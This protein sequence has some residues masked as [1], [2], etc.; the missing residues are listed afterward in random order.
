MTSS[1]LPPP[2]TQAQRWLKYGGNVVLSSIVV[3]LLAVGIVY[4]A[5]TKVR[6]IDTTISGVNSLRP[7]T[8]A[9]IGNLKGKVR[10]VSLYPLPST[11]GMSG[12]VLDDTKEQIRQTE[13]VTDLLNEYARASKNITA[14][15]LDPRR[16]SDKVDA[17]A[18]EVTAKY[19]K[20]LEPYKAFFAQFPEFAKNFDAFATTQSDAFGKLAGVKVK[21]Q[22]LAQLIQALGP[23]I[24]KLASDMKDADAAIKPLLDRSIPDYRGA[25]DRITSALSDADELLGALI[26][27]YKA[28]DERVPPELRAFAKEVTPAYEAE[29][30]AVKE[31][32][33]KTKGLKDLK[34]DAL[35]ESIKSK[36]ILVMGEEDMRVLPFSDVWQVPEDLSTL[37]TKGNQQPRLK[38]AGEQQIST[39]LVSIGRKSK[40]RVI[41]VRTGGPALATSMFRQAPFSYVAGRLRGADFEVL[42]KDLS[43]Q[44]AMQQMQGMPTPGVATD[45]Q[46]KDRSAVWICFSFE[47][48]ITQQGPNPLGGK[49]REHLTE[50]GSALVLFEANSDNLEAA[51]K[52]YGV[53]ARTDAVIVKEVHSDLAAPDSGDMIAQAE[54]LPYVLISNKYGDHPLTKPVGGLKMLQLYECPIS[55]RPPQGVI[56]APLLPISRVVKTWGDT[57]IGSL[58]AKG[59]KPP[60][61]VP[62]KDI[63]NT[64][65]SP[66]FAGAA[67][68]KSGSRLVAFGSASSF[69]NQINSITDPELEKRGYLTQRFPGNGELFVNSVFWLSHNDTMLE[70][71]PQALE[72]SRIADMSE[73]RLAFIRWGILVLGIPGLVLLCGVTVYF[74][75][76]D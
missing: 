16:Q 44:S 49:L 34:L 28:F 50:G 31:Q 32:L 1:S 36:S 48:A 11:Q 45:E 76:R 39:A 5:E 73:G 35:R 46:M 54:F 15:V 55:F 60:E 8:L 30:K 57:D 14:E 3:V 17:L 74:S 2:E 20:E 52:D 62:G 42:E 66:L 75:R 58:T 33:E 27:Q 72:V 23:T 63:S 67:A 21:D 56:G 68:D 22:D 19:G 41:F 71:S 64:E 13:T 24:L 26:N 53:S 29:D 40:P 10:L 70:I 12:Q 6:R 59:G 51:M 69:T 47:P 4:I 7:Q 61:F 9:I 65:A 38:F 37:G 18:K 25:A 43:G